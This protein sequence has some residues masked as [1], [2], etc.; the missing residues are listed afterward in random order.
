MCAP[1]R[2]DVTAAVRT[3]VSPRE[4]RTSWTPR[5]RKSRRAP[6]AGGDQR[7]PAGGL[8]G[9]ARRPVGGDRGRGGRRDRLAIALAQRAVVAAARR[10]LQ[11]E[12]GLLD[13]R[14]LLLLVLLPV[15]IVG[16]APAPAADHRGVVEPQPP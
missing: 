14:E 3:A 4:L 13:P 11:V 8:R 5:V 15:A 10:V 1:G 12:L 9:S 6:H 2:C 7:R 16:L